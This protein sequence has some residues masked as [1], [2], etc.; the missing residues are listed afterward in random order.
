MQK[1]H[2]QLSGFLSNPQIHVT[3]RFISLSDSWLPTYVMQNSNDLI[4]S[5]RTVLYSTILLDYI[6]L[7][8]NHLHF[9]IDKRK[10]VI[11]KKI[12]ISKK[13]TKKTASDHACS[14]DKTKAGY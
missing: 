9:R 2:I 1:L 11:V 6:I 8:A 14:K 5:W 13:K 4:R 10:K 12:P 7:A 3:Y